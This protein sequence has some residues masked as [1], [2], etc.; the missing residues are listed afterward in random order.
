[1]HVIEQLELETLIKFGSEIIL[2]DVRKKAAVDKEP[3]R[4]AGAVWRDHEA[5]AVWAGEIPEGTVAVCY[6]VHG[7]EVS[8]R[9]MRTLRDAGRNAYYLRGGLESWLARSG[10]LAL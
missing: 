8:Q 7:H 1:M 6:C 4:I 3:A 10:P 5:A 2:I 9:A